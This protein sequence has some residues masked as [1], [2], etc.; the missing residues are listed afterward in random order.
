MSSTNETRHVWTR[1]LRL[2]RS[3]PVLAA[4]ATAATAV[5]F[6]I[7]LL[8]VFTLSDRPALG[9]LLLWLDGAVGSRAAIEEAA[10]RSAPLLLCAAA[11]S[12]PARAGLVNIGGE[13]QMTLGM[14][15]GSLLA[16]GIAPG[17]PPGVAQSTV[18]LSAALSG[19]L[20]GGVIGAMR[21]RWGMN[22]ALVTLFLNYIMLHLIQ[23]LVQGPMRDPSSMGWPMGPRVD[24]GVRLPLLS[25]G[26]RVH[27]GIAIAIVIVGAV[28]GWLRW[29]RRGVE[30]RAVGD[31]PVAAENVGIPVSRYTV[32]ALAI[33]GAC[34]AGAGAVELLGAQYRLRPDATGGVGYAGFLVAWMAGARPAWILP[35]GFIVAAMLASSENLQ[36]TS[37]LPAAMSYVVLGLMLIW[38]LAGRQ[39]WSVLEMEQTRRR[40]LASLAATEE[41]T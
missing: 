18:L 32:L 22:E 25:E 19:A 26:T 27:L 17:L 15:V 38:I 29:T 9:T 40:S 1:S 28:I 12:V 36:V 10:L 37:G 2:P 6:L 3:K 34:A 33:G 5:G 35:L 21:A 7:S 4:A 13:G 20:L 23:Y 8:A 11:A 39:L 30:L 41:G 31:G 24:P 16:T 14:L